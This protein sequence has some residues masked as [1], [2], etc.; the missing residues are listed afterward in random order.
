TAGSIREPAAQCGV[1]GLKPTYGRVSTRG[2]IPLSW[3]LDHVG[4]ITRTVEDTAVILQVIAGYDADDTASVDVPVPDYVRGI[5]DDTRTL[6][7]GVPRRF[8]Y[9]ELDAEVSSAVD[10][11]VR[12]LDTLVMEIRDIDE[13]DLDVPTNRTLQ[14]AESYAFHKEWVEATPELYKPETLRR[15]NA[16]AKIT[17][18]DYIQRRRELEYIR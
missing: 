14:T 8:F 13:M 1:V 6:R 7:V 2:V 5:R 16:G 3:S 10:A 12:V 15:I 11:A 9:Q 18:V 17:A 4:P